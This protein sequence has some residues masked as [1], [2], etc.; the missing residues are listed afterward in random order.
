MSST[1]LFILF[2]L[3]GKGR[4][5]V[6]SVKL[7][8]SVCRTQNRKKKIWRKWMLE[9]RGGVSHHQSGFVARTFVSTLN[10]PKGAEI[11]CVPSNILCADRSSVSFITRAPFLPFWCTTEQR[12][13]KKNYFC[14]KS[15]LF[16]VQGASRAGSVFKGL[17]MIIFLI[18]T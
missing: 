1:V 3:N 16:N 5:K 4:R 7:W 6:S 11:S 2:F 17:H 10:P 8:N 18:D 12:A 15:L 14:R 9:H 13:W